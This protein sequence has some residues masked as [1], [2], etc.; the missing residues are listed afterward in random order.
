LLDLTAVPLRVLRDMTSPRLAAATART[1]DD[2]GR[3]VASAVQE[4]RE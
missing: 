1:I 4:Q 2:A 3:D